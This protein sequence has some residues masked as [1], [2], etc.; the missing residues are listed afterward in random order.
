MCGYAV[1]AQHGDEWNQVLHLLSAAN[2]ARLHVSV[3]DYNVVITACGRGG[4]WPG[5]RGLLRLLRR[6]GLR[7]SL[8]SFNAACCA[9]E[10]GPTERGKPLSPKPS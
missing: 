2:H 1:V 10:R 9:C 4:Q 7:S 3:I 5:A 8:V 6:R